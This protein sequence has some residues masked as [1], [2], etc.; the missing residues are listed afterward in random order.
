VPEFSPPNTAGRNGGNVF[1]QG[2][3]FFV[4]LA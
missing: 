1:N 2:N 3:L 4:G